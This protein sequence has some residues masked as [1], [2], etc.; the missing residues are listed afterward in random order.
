MPDSQI[1]IPCAKK[2]KI[3][4]SVCKGVNFYWMKSWLVMNNNFVRFR[5]MHSANWCFCSLDNGV[6]IV[7][8]VMK[9]PW[10]LFNWGCL[11]SP[12][13]MRD[14]PIYCEKKLDF[15][16]IF[17]YKESCNGP[18]GAECNVTVYSTVC[19]LPLVNVWQWIL[20]RQCWLCLLQLVQK[21]FPINFCC[22]GKL[23]SERYVSKPYSLQLSVKLSKIP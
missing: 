22:L 2:R 1:L 14:A 5:T 17:T 15:H 7:P 21:L 4:M 11:S 12:P 9:Y 19:W 6:T 20:H 10:S 16:Q 8:P 3:V 13:T 18:E 23:S